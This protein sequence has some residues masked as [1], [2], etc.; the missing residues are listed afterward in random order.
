M[1]SLYNMYIAEKPTPK[2]SVNYEKL[3]AARK[4]KVYGVRHVRCGLCE[5]DYVPDNL[6][7][8]T[9]RATIAKLRKGWM[10]KTDDPQLRGALETEVKGPPSNSALY[11]KVRL[12]ALCFQFVRQHNR[13]AS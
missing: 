3:P 11:D 6:P 8:I 10:S 9:T 5:Q 12:C 2:D 1:R 4:Q 13:T 7:G